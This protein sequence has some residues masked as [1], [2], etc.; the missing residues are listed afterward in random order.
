MRDEMEWIVRF[1][2]PN[3]GPGP[4]AVAS[5][6]L[7]AEYDYLVVL[8]LRDHY[9]Q[10]SRNRAQAFDDELAAFENRDVGV[11]AALPDSQEKAS[12]WGRRYDLSYPV[13]ADTVAQVDGADAG[14]DAQAM[15]DGTPRFDAFAEIE[16]RLETLPAIGV[17]DTRKRWPRLVDTFG[18]DRL[19]DCPT[20]EEVRR[21]LDRTTNN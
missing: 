1:D 16:T 2:L 14:G 5:D 15:T 9:C 3:G 19:Q 21:R 6:D 7:T 4:D 18:G 12:F 10:V 20:P 8:L 17:L 11:V 13:L